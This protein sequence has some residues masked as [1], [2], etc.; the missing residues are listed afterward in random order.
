MLPEVSPVS[1]I[2]ARLTV[3][4]FARGGGTGSGTLE[5][6]VAAEFEALSAA[7]FAAAVGGE[8]LAAGAIAGTGADGAGSETGRDGDGGA[9]SCGPIAGGSELAV[10]SASARV[11]MTVSPASL[12]MPP[13]SA[14]TSTKV[15]LRSA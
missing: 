1:K 8:S 2:R 13:A 3:M 14:R 12:E 15:T 6:G 7:G 9:A 11:M 4:V 10:A 5:P